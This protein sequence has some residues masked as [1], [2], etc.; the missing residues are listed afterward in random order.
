MFMGKRNE[1]ELPVVVYG[2]K[3]EEGRRAGRGPRKWVINGLEYAKKFE[4]DPKING[5]HEGEEPPSQ[6]G[7]LGSSMC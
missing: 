2:W 4:L 7:H 3:Q 5:K 6:I 1:S